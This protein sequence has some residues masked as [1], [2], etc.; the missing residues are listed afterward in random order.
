[1]PNQ[2]SDA[3]RGRRERLARGK[4]LKTY[5]VLAGLKQFELADQIGISR[6]FISR[7]ER[8]FSNLPPGHVKK[9]ARLLGVTPEVLRHGAQS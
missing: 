5:R 3:A 6:E 8:G 2:L 1:M 4:I 7:V 9:V